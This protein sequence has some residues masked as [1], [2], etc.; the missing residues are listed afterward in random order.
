[1]F[2]GLHGLTGTPTDVAKV[3]AAKAAKSVTDKVAMAKARASKARK[4]SGSN[5]R[6]SG[7]VPF[8]KAGSDN[9][10]DFIGDLVDERM[11]A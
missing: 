10:E 4:A 9:V 6:S 5:V 1:M 7:A 3:D 2:K 11:T 8:S